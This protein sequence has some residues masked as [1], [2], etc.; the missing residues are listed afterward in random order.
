[1]AIEEMRVF[2]MTS[3]KSIFLNCHT[4]TESQRT[5]A[6]SNGHKPVPLDSDVEGGAKF[7]NK[8]DNTLVIHR[9]IG[10]AI[11]G[12]KY[13]TEI[14]VRKVRNQE[15]GG[16]PTPFTDPIR[17]RYRIDRTGFDLDNQTKLTDYK[18]VSFYE[19]ETQPF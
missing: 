8:A 10:S 5:K 12:E 17:I 19:K 4:V 6:D 15:F 13:V 16:E 7:P 11:P 9:Q 14:H 2:T 3:N 1:M 18:Q